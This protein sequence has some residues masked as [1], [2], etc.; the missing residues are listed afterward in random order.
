MVVGVLLFE[1]MGPVAMGAVVAMLGLA[2]IWLTL[3]GL[4]KTERPPMAAMGV[5]EGMRATFQNR[6]FRRLFVCV[7]DD[8]A[9]RAAAGGLLF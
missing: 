9:D 5:M 1:W 2:T 3:A 7:V 6:Q 8:G 4:R